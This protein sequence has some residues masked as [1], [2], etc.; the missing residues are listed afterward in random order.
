MRVLITG[1]GGFVGRNFAKRLLVLGYDV[2]G[3]DDLSAGLH[4][5][6]WTGTI[7]NK[8]SLNYFHLDVRK[9]F[10][11]FNPDKFDLVIHCAAIVGGRRMIDGDPLAVAT[12]MS[13]DA[14]LFNWIVRSKKMPRLIYFSSSAAYPADLQKRNVHCQLVEEFLNFDGT[15]IGLPEMTYGFVKIAGE[16]LAKCAVEKYGLDVKIY[17]PFGGYGGDQSFD[18]PFPSIVKRVVDREDPITVWGSG[19]QL[20]DFIHIDDIVEA[21]LNAMDAL[22]SGQPLNLGTGVG[23]SFKELAYKTAVLFDRSPNVVNDASKQEGVFA[24]VADVHKLHQYYVPRITL[25]EGIRRVYEH[26][27]DCAQGVV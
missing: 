25:E 4:P 23:T 26:L 16:Y 24:R 6:K 27:T 19:D 12:D 11:M 5:S 8:H 22:P 3:V 14:E 7:I 18:Y 17:R 9:F 20:R 10:K 13:I 21:V 1:S 15:R 2:V